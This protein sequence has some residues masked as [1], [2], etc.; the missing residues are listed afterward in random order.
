MLKKL[1][2]S[3]KNSL[4]PLPS[5]I[6]NVVRFIVVVLWKNLTEKVS[7]EEKASLEEEKSLDERS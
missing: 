1:L 7:E 2:F 6:K 4:I 5:L 3:R